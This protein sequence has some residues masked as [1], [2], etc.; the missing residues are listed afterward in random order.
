MQCRRI[1][2]IAGYAYI[3]ILRPACLGWEGQGLG[4]EDGSEAAE[5]RG[6]RGTEP[7]NLTACRVRAL[8]SRV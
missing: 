7:Q 8:G 5:G 3:A 6:V 2:A 4:L 1:V